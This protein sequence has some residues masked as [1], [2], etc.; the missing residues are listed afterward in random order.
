MTGLLHH[1]AR[2]KA[3]S[4]VTVA[5]QTENAG[6]ETKQRLLQIGSDASKSGG[7]GTCQAKPRAGVSEADC[8][9][10]LSVDTVMLQRCFEIRL[11]K[12]PRRV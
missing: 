2:P 7:S 1:E 4:D 11:Q 9:I 10:G 5:S 12:P 8:R 6:T 3:D